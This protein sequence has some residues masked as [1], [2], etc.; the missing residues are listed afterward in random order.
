MLCH[1]LRWQKFLQQ[2]TIKQQR[3]GSPHTACCSSNLSTHSSKSQSC[4]WSGCQIHPLVGTEHRAASPTRCALEFARAMPA[5]SGSLP[6][7]PVDWRS[8]A[9]STCMP[10]IYRGA[11]GHRDSLQICISSQSQAQAGDSSLLT[12]MGAEGSGQTSFPGK[13]G[14]GDHTPELWLREP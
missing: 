3:Q 7:L 13:Q 8:P 5:L 11:A 2:I 1:H 9:L 6:L 12:R 4:S 10:G 14:L